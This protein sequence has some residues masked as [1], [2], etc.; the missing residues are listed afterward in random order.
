MGGFVIIG[1]VLI[2]SFFFFPRSLALYCLSS[3]F[4]NNFLFKYSVSQ[5]NSVSYS[6]LIHL[7]PLHLFLASLI[8]QLV[9]NLPAMQET[10]V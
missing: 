8:A 3:G 7:V 1:F 4:R 9:N 2:D 6:S 10:P 5:G